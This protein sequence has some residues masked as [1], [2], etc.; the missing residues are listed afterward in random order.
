MAT[1]GFKEANRGYKLVFWPMTV[2]YLV[3]VLGTSWFV[4]TETSA[5]WVRVVCALATTAPVLAM[6]WSIIRHTD[7]TDEYTRI[8]QLRG[9]AVAGAVT[10]GAVFIVGFLQ[11]FDA[12]GAVDVFWFGPFYFLAFGLNRCAGLFRS[13]E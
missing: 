12:L 13:S 11:M 7:E 8:R 2:L 3:V 4:A 9:L 6:L 5:Q 1:V 10:A